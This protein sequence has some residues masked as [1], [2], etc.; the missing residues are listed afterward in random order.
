MIK[1]HYYYIEAV[2][3]EL[4]GL[5]DLEVAVKMENGMFIAPISEKYVYHYYKS[6][7]KGIIDILY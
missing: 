4:F 7:S 2:H 6:S 1:N 5:D 3:K